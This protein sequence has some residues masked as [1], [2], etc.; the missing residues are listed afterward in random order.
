[1]A[2]GDQGT[3]ATGDVFSVQGNAGGTGDNTNALRP[4]INVARHPATGTMS[5]SGAVS[6]LISGSGTQAEQVNSAQTAQSAVNKQAQTNL[7]SI[8][9]VNLDEEAAQIM[10]WQQSYQASAQV[11]SVANGLFTT[12]IDSVNGA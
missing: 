11:L 8:S 7:Q 4:P 10:Q 12:L 6:G 3:P 1:M 9:G 5:I 2:G